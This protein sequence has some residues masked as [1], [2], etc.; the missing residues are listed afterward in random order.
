MI[1]RPAT[2][3]PTWGLV[4]P[5]GFMGGWY[6]ICGMTT[7]LPNPSVITFTEQNINYALYVRHLMSQM[8]IIVHNR[9]DRQSVSSSSPAYPSLPWPP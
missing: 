6:P 7:K 3:S 8:D 1:H 5:T 9:T 2:V 4:L